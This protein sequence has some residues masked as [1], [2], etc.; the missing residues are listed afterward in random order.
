MLDRKTAEL[1]DGVQINLG[2][3]RMEA[4]KQDRATSSPLLDIY[5]EVLVVHD[6]IQT[7]GAML[8]ERL[9][10][11]EY[12]CTPWYIKLYRKVKSWLSTISH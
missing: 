3:Y 11:L 2:G 12:M 1:S 8:T 10:R 4:Q 7:L 9:N 6:E 5:T